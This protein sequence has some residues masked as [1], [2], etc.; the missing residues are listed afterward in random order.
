MEPLLKWAGGKRLLLPKIYK[1]IKKEKILNENTTLYEPFVGGG[2]LFLDLELPNC[3][4]ND[5]N[6]ELINVYRQVKYKPY[7]LIKL[8]NVHKTNHSLEYYNTIRN[9]DRRPEYK[10]MKKVEK[11]ARIIYLNKT[12]YN[13]LYRV[14]AEGYFNVPMGKYLN[15][16]IVM[17][18]KILELSKYLKKNNVIIR[19]GDFVDAVK[20]AKEGD[21]VYFD[22]PY[23]YEIDGFTSYNSTAFTK[24]DLQRLKK[25]SDDLINKGCIVVISNNDTQF[26]N[27]LFSENNYIIDHIEANRLINC[28]GKRRKKEKEVIIYGTKG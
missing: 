2:S 15:P 4:I 22:P 27:E 18:D 9:L 12:C 21:V 23:D 7:E 10:K 11:A 8:L 14:N 25:C 6:I 13:G 3:V 28:D 5:F 16:D 19:C 20:D 1:Y 26:V 17:K 24:N